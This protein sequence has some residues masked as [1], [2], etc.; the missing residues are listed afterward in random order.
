MLVFRFKLYLGVV[1]E[2]VTFSKNILFFSYGASLQPPGWVMPS[3]VVLSK[4]N[5][6]TAGYC[7]CV[8]IFYFHT[9]INAS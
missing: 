9:H 6:A 7:G 2:Q 4:N 5:G 8:Y 1:V 3:K